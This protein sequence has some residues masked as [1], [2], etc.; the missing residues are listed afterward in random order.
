MGMMFLTYERRAHNA[1]RRVRAS[2]H[3]LAHQ[4]EVRF[5]AH[6]DLPNLSINN[7][8]LK[9][10]DIVVHDPAFSTDHI[11]WAQKT[12]SGFTRGHLFLTLD[13]REVHGAI[14]LGTSEEDAQEFHVYGNTAKPFT[15]KTQ[16]K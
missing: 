10:G 12:A 2:Y 14:Q 16:I 13:R 5:T 9:V 8:K 4:E 15:Y 11:S 1:T 3:L 7:G 6:P